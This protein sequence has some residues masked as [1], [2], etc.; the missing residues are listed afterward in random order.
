MGGLK[1][2]TRLIELCRVSPGSRVLVVGSGAGTTACLLAQRYRCMVTGIDLSNE[3]V[4]R[5][6]ERARR[7]GLAAQTRFLIAA[8]Q[9]LPF[10]NDF[11]DAVLCES[12]NAFIPHKEKALNEY[13]RV[14]RQKGY[15]GFNEVT[16]LKLP[17]AD[18]DKYLRRIMGAEFLTAEGWKKLFANPEIEEITADIYKTG[19][20][21]QWLEEIKQFD[22]SDFFKAWL[23]F[24]SMLFSSRATRKF[25]FEALSFPASIFCLFDYFGYGIYTGRK[26]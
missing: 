19:V 6:S 3:M 20:F 15:I 23:R 21:R 7:K 22:A 18:L 1:A 2:T 5:A 9:N 25:T 26:G 14:S 24:F 11:F 12:V 8:A 4:R 17:P 10:E 13:I 16:W